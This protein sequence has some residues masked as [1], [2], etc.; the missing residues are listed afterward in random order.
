MSSVV[1]QFRDSINTY[2]GEQPEADEPWYEDVGNAVTNFVNPIL[3]GMVSGAVGSA[4]GKTGVSNKISQGVAKQASTTGIFDTDSFAKLMGGAAGS[5]P[6]AIALPLV[7]LDYGIRAGNTAGAVTFLSAESALNGE[8]ASVPYMRDGISFGDIGDLTKDAWGEDV[9]VELADGTIVTAQNSI[10]AGQAISTFVGRTIHFGIGRVNPDFIETKDEHVEFYSAEEFNADWNERQ[11]YS[12]QTG[13][14]SGFDVTDYKQRESAFGQGLGRWVSGFSDAAIQ[15]YVGVDVLAAKAA[16]MTG[17]ALL[18]KNF[19]TLQDVN[20]M[21]DESVAHDAFRKGLTEGQILDE[22][23]AVLRKVRAKETDLGR[24]Y[25]SFVRMNERQVL[26]HSV[27]TTSNDKLLVARVL[28]NANDYE[29]VALAFRAFGGDKTAVDQL[30]KL[31]AIAGDALSYQRSRIE[32]LRRV[33][34]FDPLDPRSQDTNWAVT[35]IGRLNPVFEAA[36]KENLPLRNL[37][38]SFSDGLPTLKLNQI[39]LSKLS[40]GPN[41]VGRMERQA[42]KGALRAERGLYTSTSFR[43]GGGFGR[44]VRVMKSPVDYMR[45]AR[46]MGKVDLTSADK[47]I[48]EVDAIFSTTNYFRALAKTSP[49]KVINEQ[50][51]TVAM[52]RERVYAEI[53]QAQSSSERWEVFNRFDS[54][55]TRLLSEAYG[56]GP[57]RVSQVVGRYQE[58]KT[59][60]LE[61]VQRHG[62][63]EDSGEMIVVKQIQEQLKGMDLLSKK[64][65]TYLS[66]DFNFLETVFRL[67]TGSGLRRK[68]GSLGTGFDELFSRFDSVW[69]P[70]VLMR[71]GYTQRNVADGWLREL[72]AF[73]TI[74]GVYQRGAGGKM[75][76]EDQAFV[77]WASSA[78]RVVDKVSGVGRYVTNGSVR[79]NLRNIDARRNISVASGELAYG[80]Q[81]RLSNV[82][83]AA[84][85]R[86]KLL[87][88]EARERLANSNIERLDGHVGVV[89]E[90]INADAAASAAVKFANAQEVW[91]PSQYVEPLLSPISGPAF[92]RSRTAFASDSVEDSVMRQINDETIPVNSIDEII[93]AT[94]GTSADGN[95]D[96]L[97]KF[98]GSRERT[99]FARLRQMSLDGGLEPSAYDRFAKLQDK[100]YRRAITN[101]FGEGPGKL[102]GNR[103][104]RTLDTG[105]Y[106]VI[107]SLDD[108][109]VNDVLDGVI[110][111][112]RKE[113]LDRVT[114][115]RATSYG[116]VLDFRTSV[117]KLIKPTIS[118]S[119]EAVK[120]SDFDEDPMLPDL[121]ESIFGKTPEVSRGRMEDYLTKLI[122]VAEKDPSIVEAI[123]ERAMLQSLPPEIFDG[124]MKLGLVVTSK[125]L[126]SLVKDIPKRENKI[127]EM[128][129]EIEEAKDRMYVLIEELDL[130][131]F[132]VFHGGTEIKGGIPNANPLDTTADPEAIKAGVG[133][134]FSDNKIVGGPDYII[135]RALDKDGDPVLYAAMVDDERSFLHLDDVLDSYEAEN[136][137]K[138]ILS[139]MAER[140][141]MDV[142]DVD[143][144]DF[145]RDIEYGVRG[146]IY[147][148]QFPTN[149]LDEEELLDYTIDE[150]RK[151]MVAY[152]T[153]EGLSEYDAQMLWIESLR[154]EGYNGVSMLGGQ[155]ARGTVD[156]SVFVF[157]NPPVVTRVDEISDEAIKLKL[158]KNKVDGLFE[159]LEY[160]QRN[161]DVRR[162]V[163][164]YERKFDARNMTVNFERK[165]GVLMNQTGRGR[166]FVDDSLSPSGYR[167]IVNPDMMAVN[168]D[169]LDAVMPGNIVGRSYVDRTLE[170]LQTESTTRHPQVFVPSGLSDEALLAEFDGSKL[171]LEYLRTGKGSPEVKAKVGRYMET[172]SGADGGALPFTHVEIGGGGKFKTV[173]EILGRKMTGAAYRR[174]LDGDELDAMTTML[175]NNDPEMSKFNLDIGSL[176]QETRK[177]Q[178]DFLRDQQLARDASDKLKARLG[179]KAD[180]RQTKKYLGTG[181]EDISG[182]GFESFDTPG[183]LAASNQGAMNAIESGSDSRVQMDLHGLTDRS[184]RLLSATSGRT[185]YSPGDDQYWFA[186]SDEVNKI[187]RNDI[188]GRMTLEGAGAESIYDALKLT[189]EGRAWIRDVVGISDFRG[190]VTKDILTEN[191]ELAVITE[192]ADRQAILTR[193]L[194]A[195][196]SDDQRRLWDHMATHDVS[197][198]WLRT[199]FGWRSDLQDLEGLGVQYKLGKNW[200]SFTASAMRALGSVPEN[201]LNRHPFYR[202]RWREEMIRQSEIYGPQIAREQG[203]E[204][205][206]FTEGMI[207][208]MNR[209]AKDYAIRQVNDTLYTILQV[210]TPA[211]MFRYIVPFFPAWASAMK[212]WLLKQPVEKPETL[213]RYGLAFNAPEAIGVY[214]DQDGQ[215]ID[216]PNVEGNMVPALFERLTSKVK[217]TAE[218]VL[219][220]QLSPSVAKAVDSAVGG[221]TILGVSKGSLDFLLQGNYF[222]LPGFGP[223]VTIPLSWLAGLKPDIATELETGNFTGLSQ[224][225]PVSE[226]QK[227]LYGSALPFGPSKEKN[228]L[229]IVTEQVLPG[230]LSRPFQAAVRGTDSVAFSNA[231][232]EIYRTS[233][234]DWE[235]SDR[236]GEKPSFLKAIEQAK[237]FSYFRGAV[238]FVSPVAVSF[239]S[240]YQFYV[241]EWRRME[242]AAYEPGGGGL[243]AA[244][245]EFFGKYGTEFFAATL[246]LSAGSSGISASVGEYRAFESNPKLMA[247]LATYGDDASYITMATR[248]WAAALNEN[249]F[250]PAVYANQFNRPIEGASGKYLRAGSNEREDLLLSVD[251]EIGWYKFNNKT[252]RYDAMLQTGSIDSVQYDRLR[253]AAAREIGVENEGWWKEYNDRGGARYIDSTRALDDILGNEKWMK[254]NGDS[255]YGQ[256][257]V[258]FRS[259]RDY[260]VNL[261]RENKLSGG[262]DNIDAK[263]NLG[264]REAYAV[265]V[266][267]IAAGDPSGEFIRMHERFFGSDKLKPIPG[268]D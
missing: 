263:Q 219:S 154:E 243:D 98:M 183:P 213:A 230:T 158:L 136:E 236:E 46:Q 193:L 189:T 113:N 133:M 268:R 190:M 161:L 118:D 93:G 167:L 142:S 70:L 150:Y 129:D 221:N 30:T 178:T 225:I 14:Y 84:S 76:P 52:F 54:S 248:P 96:L 79:R 122:E 117:S 15:W 19:D 217:G 10:T 111:V 107:H 100:A 169:Q 204:V 253:L 176:Q 141:G 44:V 232:T 33:L 238:S 130:S 205:G 214:K 155:T 267:Q 69:R 192:I 207:N 116:D 63:F 164:P 29:T 48:R 198:M 254:D 123:A 220:I 18:T 6:A 244:Q 143:I 124:M 50:G 119:I 147:D 237:T 174:D 139:G 97:E 25:E 179:R 257:L 181:M 87:E 227:A 121:Y 23:G 149:L 216:D 173:S 90:E 16:G 66:T 91:I 261:L 28:G 137:L 103:V 68:A 8:Y 152:F 22:T 226:I 57:D 177:T 95:L 249:G 247:T 245:T 51:E 17:R 32:N 145:F 235:L 255:V 13:L 223:L 132:D 104:V 127:S 201:R 5:V 195:T 92:R 40:Y 112:V 196:D 135:S 47:V 266:A 265:G 75:N 120:K 239:R 128:T 61:Q 172:R 140:S 184:Q 240:K 101:A 170:A 162:R 114:H 81:Q 215:N 43:T 74:G 194:P 175:M 211:H 203:V 72:A 73:G 71:L 262:S 202:A 212:F 171:V 185:T 37:V 65:E 55:V 259:M 231:A 144:D 67:E 165:L 45:T 200:R 89:V 191:A 99:E 88:A 59:A 233:I 206:V 41:S 138:R 159:K 264:I 31:D 78:G 218:G 251:K 199:E 229:D 157:Y 83:R 186:F 80:A 4:A 64:A 20:K 56:I 7:A 35:E 3:Q 102:N 86:V 115:V 160:D 9:E 210:S 21:A 11:L 187:W 49:D 250:D 246:S 242:Q 166:I 105:L 26:R 168:T 224:F 241:D 252:D 1:K 34:N 58:Y 180:G 62:Y 106:E 148:A 2:G 36:L 208:T 256:S 222:W 153:R 126:Q 260:Y 82:E 131:E 134:Y 12:W 151:E 94:D 108:I 188:V 156:H 110:G 146:S 182:K 197:P 125:K 24:L 42:G 38:A 109:N 85:A 228:V 77:K 209:V 60:L 27:A 258:T 163:A 234:I 39:R 53:I